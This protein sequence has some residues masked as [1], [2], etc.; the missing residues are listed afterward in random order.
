M[1]S[2]VKPPEDP[3]ALA[4]LLGGQAPAA[5][6][7]PTAKSKKPATKAEASKLPAGRM[8]G[9]CT[10]KGCTGKLTDLSRAHIG[11]SQTQKGRTLITLICS[12][13]SKVQAQAEIPD[14]D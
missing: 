9:P 3:A 2:S 1:G 4:K 5:G 12:K 6:G 10:Q 11:K 13:C 14:L 7:K 8:G